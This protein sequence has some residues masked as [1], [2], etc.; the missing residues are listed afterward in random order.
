MRIEPLARGQRLS[1]SLKKRIHF[2]LPSLRHSI[3]VVALGSY[4]A[5]A[6]G[7]PLPEPRI[8]RDSR[9]FPCQHHQ[10]GCRTADQCWQRCCCYTPA[11]RRAWARA[12]GVEAEAIA[13]EDRADEDSNQV[14]ASAAGDQTDRCCI[15]PGRAKTVAH[16]QP[17]CHQS[18]CHDGCAHHAGQ[19]KP[20]ESNPPQ[21]KRHKSPSGLAGFH[22]LGCQGIATLW[23]TCGAV[24]PLPPPVSGAE[25]PEVSGTVSLRFIAPRSAEITPPDPPPRLA[26]NV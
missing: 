16:G 11:E 22:A 12:H 17:A 23:V 4:L 21:G 5:V 3:A 15:T 20:D 2:R 6:G 25:R 14:T 9:P 1:M 26:A 24:A 13:A 10:C 8:S 19:H 7:V 18:A